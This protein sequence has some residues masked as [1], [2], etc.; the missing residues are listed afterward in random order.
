M[1][2]SADEDERIQIKE[3]LNWINTHYNTLITTKLE[4]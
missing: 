1:Y 3:Y 2:D 4:Y